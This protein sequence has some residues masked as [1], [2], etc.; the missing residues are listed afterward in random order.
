MVVED[1]GSMGDQ[2]RNPIMGVNKEVQDDD[3]SDSES[4][5]CESVSDSGPESVMGDDCLMCSDTKEEAV[6]SACK[7][8]CKKVWA[9]HSPTKQGIWKD[10]QLEQIRNN[11]NTV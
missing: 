3:E 4:D 6:K 9:S 2:D 7:R 5:L 10:M 8:F 1:S 11:C